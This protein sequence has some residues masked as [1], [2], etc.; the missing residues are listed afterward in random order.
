[1]AP[2]CRARIIIRYGHPNAGRVSRSYWAGKIL[3]VC[4]SDEFA[5]GVA[6]E[7]MGIAE[8]DGDGEYY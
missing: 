3:F 1:M 6:Q 7:E 5:R 4:S 2:G 8:L